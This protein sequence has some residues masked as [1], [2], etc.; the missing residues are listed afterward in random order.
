[1]VNFSDNS[2]LRRGFKG[3]LCDFWNRDISRRTAESQ[4]CFPKVT[5]CPFRCQL[6]LENLYYIV[7][8][9]YRLS[10]LDGTGHDIYRAAR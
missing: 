5:M 1:M 2:D 4:I 6:A 7:Y 9:I 3:N 8:L 10:S